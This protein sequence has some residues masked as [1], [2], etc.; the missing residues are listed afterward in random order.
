MEHDSFPG[1][2]VTVVFPSQP[3]PEP[4]GPR[5][6][7]LEDKRRLQVPARRIGAG[8]LSGALFAQAAGLVH[9]WV[10]YWVSGTTGQQVIELVIDAG[11]SGGASEASTGFAS[12]VSARGATRQ[13]LTADLDGYSSPFQVNGR[14]YALIT[15]PLA[16]GPFFFILYVLAPEQ[17]SSADATLLVNL[18]AAQERKVPANTPD[19]GTSLSDLLADPYHA[20]GVTLGALL[21]YLAIVFCRGQ[22]A[23][24]MVTPR[25]A[26]R[27][28]LLPP[29]VTNS[30]PV[31]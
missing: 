28:R 31:M 8:Q 30:D 29:S 24:E 9:G 19:T 26:H 14:P 16:R 6:R 3:E 11:T 2:W 10:R 20:A 4:Y 13:Q 23:G 18:A 21:A 25:L 1:P 7:L 12:S 17:S 27:T 15:T 5:D 22:H